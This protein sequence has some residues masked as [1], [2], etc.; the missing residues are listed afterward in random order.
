MRIGLALG[1]VAA[2][3]TACKS[4]P[5]SSSNG[6]SSG[7]SSSTADTAVSTGNSQSSGA[8][9]SSG[10]AAATIGGS[11]ANVNNSSSA[12]TSSGTASSASSNGA[13]G[14]SGSMVTTTASGV[15]TS[16]GDSCASAI[17]C[18]DFEDYT[19]GEPPDG[20]WSPVTNAGSVAI[21]D[22]RRVSGTHSVRFDTQAGDGSKTAYVRLESASIFPVPNNTYYGRMLFWLESAPTAAVH[23]TF[24]QGGGTVPGQTYRALYRYGGQHPVSGGNQL[25]ANYETPDS[26][27]GNGPRSDCWKHAEGVVVPE[28][29][30]SCVEWKFDGMLDEMRLWLDGEA[31]DS[32]TVMGSGEGCVSADVN[33][34]WTAPN[35]EYLEIGWESYQPDEERTLFIDDL[36]IDTA[37]IGCPTLP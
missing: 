27:G 16:G 25:M 5:S 4:D 17:F 30:W 20:V 18:D 19:L 9:A 3:I 37:P 12:A 32:L 22:S 34:T 15:G 35:F 21:D 2:L 13:G 1:A 10:N 24:L 7:Q 8:V 31:I 29:R 33:N 6:S 11:S 14:A 28:G 36:V 23:W 26:Y